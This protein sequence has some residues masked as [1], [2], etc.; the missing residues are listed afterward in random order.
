MA[1]RAPPKVRPRDPG[2]PRH[3]RNGHAPSAVFRTKAPRASTLCARPPPSSAARSGVFCPHISSDTDLV[4]GTRLSIS[5]THIFHKKKSAT[6]KSQQVASLCFREKPTR[7]ASKPPG[8]TPSPGF[9]LLS[10]VVFRARAYTLLVVESSIGVVGE[11]EAP[12]G[13][14]I[15]REARDHGPDE[16]VVV[17]ARRS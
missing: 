9:P 13:T 15:L 14:A 10:P 8:Q 5:A 16:V 17:G 4:H 7:H 6:H 2:L 3:G 11:R 1:G 12:K